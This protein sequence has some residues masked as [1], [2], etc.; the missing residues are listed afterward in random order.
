MAAADVLPK[1]EAE[2]AADLEQARELYQRFQPLVG[3]AVARH[4]AANTLRG[5]SGQGQI[6]APA[7]R[8]VIDLIE[9]ALGGGSALRDSREVQVAGFEEPR[10]FVAESEPP[11]GGST[12]VRPQLRMRGRR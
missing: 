3:R 2:E 6:D 11:A 9:L 5:A 4:S 1:L 7:P 12:L 8:G 10:R